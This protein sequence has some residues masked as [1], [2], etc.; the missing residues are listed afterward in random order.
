MEEEQQEKISNDDDSLLEQSELADDRVDGPTE[1][2]IGEGESSI[3]EEH[4]S[5]DLKNESVKTEFQDDVHV[6]AE[7]QSC[8]PS[9]ETPTLGTQPLRC[10]ACSGK[11][12]RHTCA[13][14]GSR[15]PRSSSSASTPSTE[16]FAKYTAEE[17][18]GWHGFR[19]VQVR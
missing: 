14:G 17:F 18:E 4:Y 12:V 9:T 7:A 3:T 15:T 2:T 6:E 19:K 1:A 16:S 8:T 11:H 13:K 5:D 10:D